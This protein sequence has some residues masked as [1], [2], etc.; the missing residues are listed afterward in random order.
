MKKIVPT[1]VFLIV[2]LTFSH[3]SAT[4]EEAALAAQ[5]FN[6]ATIL[7]NKAKPQCGEL[8][9]KNKALADAVSELY[10]KAQEKQNA[11][12][13]I[14]ANADYL[15]KFL[16]ERIDETCGLVEIA[17]EESV[18]IIIA[19]EFEQL[20]SKHKRSANFEDFIDKIF[21]TEYAKLLYLVTSVSTLEKMYEKWAV[22]MVADR[23]DAKKTVSNIADANVE[24]KKELADFTKT[25]QLYYKKY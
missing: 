4:E 14:F 23:K 11:A 18:R 20:L 5:L 16:Q 7:L 3:L 12:T 10:R 15:L 17:N 8:K 22:K 13:N 9:Q 21:G 25:F 2:L 1:I 24:L 19:R 6:Q